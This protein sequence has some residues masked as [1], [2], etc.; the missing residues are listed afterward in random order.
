MQC[1]AMQCNAMHVCM[2][3]HVCTYIYM[4]MYLHVFTCMSIHIHVIYRYVSDDLPRLYPPFRRTSWIAGARGRCLSRPEGWVL[5]NGA[6]CVY[7]YIIYIYII[8]IYTMCVYIYILT[9]T[10]RGDKVMPHSSRSR[11]VCMLCVYIYIV[12]IV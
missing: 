12:V 6:L 10:I 5:C 3:I 7:I 9:T 1:N 8:Y 11:F 4:Y 2:Y